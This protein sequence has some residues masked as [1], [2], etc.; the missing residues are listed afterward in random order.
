MRSMTT[1]TTTHGMGTALQQSPSGSLRWDET[2]HRMIRSADPVLNRA[3]ISGVVFLDSNSNGQMDQDERTLANVRV[4]VDNTIVITDENGHYE[5]L[6]VIPMT[7]A[8]VSLDTMSLMC[9][10]CL[11]PWS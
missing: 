7:A 11:F 8:T 9:K 10:G 2:M 5:M 3:G 4:R 1:A 6:G